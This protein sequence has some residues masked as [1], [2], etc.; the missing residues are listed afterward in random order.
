MTASA[1]AL[2]LS[3]FALPGP[4]FPTA[5]AQEQ[6]PSQLQMQP[7]SLTP[8]AGSVRATYNPSIQGQRATY[9]GAQQGAPALSPAQPGVPQGERAVQK[10][11][12][13]VAEQSGYAL[14][15]QVMRARDNIDP[16]KAGIKDIVTLFFNR[17]Q[18]ALIQ[19][20]RESF[21]TRPTTE[22]EVQQEAVKEESQETQGPIQNQPP[23]P[24]PDPGLR[25]ISLG[26]IL[27]AGGTDWTVW[28]NNERVKPDA[29]PKEVM[30]IRVYDK[31]V[32]LK[33]YDAYTKRVF[34][35]RLRPHQRF[36][37]DSRIFL[38]GEGVR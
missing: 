13:S 31:F 19:E 16:P 37:L 21:Y 30:D 32:D 10:Q 17:W 38:P 4:V 24:P 27:F 35:V 5:L 23:R 14:L 3:A 6:P 9:K 33:W 12:D 36:N 8:E 34:P 15:E 7:A 1:L 18:H 28:L 29:I 26:G 11:P 20:A 2:L 25:E 22:G